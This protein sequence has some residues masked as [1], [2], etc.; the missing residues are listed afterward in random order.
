MAE[1]LRVLNACRQI[2]FQTPA[3]KIVDV[4]RLSINDLPDP[5]TRAPRRGCSM[6]NPDS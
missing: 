3:K 6:P 2:Q 5:P 1:A 4:N